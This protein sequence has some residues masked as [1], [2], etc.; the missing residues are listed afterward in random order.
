MGQDEYRP[1][2]GDRVHAAGEGAV[3]ICENGP[4]L[5]ARQLPG[6]CRRAGEAV[7]RGHG[8]VVRQRQCGAVAE[9]VAVHRG[10]HG[11]ED[12]EPQRRPELV[13]HLREGARRSRL[14][15]RR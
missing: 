3:C 1:D 15:R 8:G 10:T 7:M 9:F 5:F 4:G 14:L 11:P 12:C 6:R 13:G 2:S